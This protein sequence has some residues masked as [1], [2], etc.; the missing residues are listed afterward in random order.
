VNNYYAL[1]GPPQF[2]Y[3]CTSP[4]LSG[5]GN[6]NVN[7]QFLDG[8]HIAST[9]PC[10]GA[11]SPQY[12]GGTDVD[13]EAWATPPAMGC[14]EVILTNLVGPLSVNLVAW[15][16]NVLVNRVAS[17]WEAYT[18]RASTS[19]WSFGDGTTATNTWLN[20]HQW[21]SPG[22]FPVT[23]TVYNNDNPGG[24]AATVVVHV[25]ALA[26]PQLQA[27][28]ALTN[29]FQFQFTGQS[30]ANYTIQYATN[31]VPPVAWQ[32]LQRVFFNNQNVVQ[33]VDG[34]WTNAARFYRV[35]VQ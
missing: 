19:S 21:T 7:P 16:T 20:A 15:Q 3:C 35:L 10:R 14:D 11:G 23:Y 22:D 17:F 33:I 30:N 5:N 28:I 8:M 12:A 31:L 32:T 25:Q 2:L 27:S 29:G 26:V 4:T 6:I 18:G 13:G 9:S 34:A 24:V 1:G